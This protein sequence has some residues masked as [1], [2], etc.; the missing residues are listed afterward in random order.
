ME[1]KFETTYGDVTIRDCVIDT[2]GTNLEE[3]ISVKLDNDLLAEIVG[4]STDEFENVLSVENL[5]EA[6]L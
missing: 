3:G 5:V 1:K 4:M 2:D 6:L